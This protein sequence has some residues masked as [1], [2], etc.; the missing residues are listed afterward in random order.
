M[1]ESSIARIIG[2]ARLIAILLMLG[3]TGIYTWTYITRGANDQVAFLTASL[4]LVG[5]AFLNLLYNYLKG[6][7]KWFLY[8]LFLFSAMVFSSVGDFLMAGLFYITSDTLINGIIFF[9]I[10][11]LFYILALRTRSPLL[12]RPRSESPTEAPDQP[13]LLLVNLVIL[14]MCFIAVTGLFYFTVFNPTQIEMSIAILCYGL[15]FATVIAFAIT[16]WFDDFQI[17]F[18]I[19]IV[20][21]FLLFFFSD[22]VIGVRTFASSDFLDSFAVGITYLSGQ[23]L[24]HL[25]PIAAAGG[26]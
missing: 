21:G 19:A 12:L 16:K 8:V 26:E 4:A 2:Y 13:R 11:H 24:I 3:I 5:I 17:L 15:L 18:K 14:I 1:S 22:W 10:G 23:L 25:S 7:A 6:D 9:T 20:A